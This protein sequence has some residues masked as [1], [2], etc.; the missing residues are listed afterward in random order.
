MLLEK[1][2][3]CLLMIPSVFGYCAGLLLQSVA[4]A[5]LGTGPGW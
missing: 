4:I 1:P 5:T 2:F 3:D